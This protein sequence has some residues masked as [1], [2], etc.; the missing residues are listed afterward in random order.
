MQKPGPSQDPP[1][2]AGGFAFIGAGQEAQSKAPIQETN[3]PL[4][5]NEMRGRRIG[6]SLDWAM[7]IGLANASQRPRQPARVVHVRGCLPPYPGL[8]DGLTD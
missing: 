5:S 2:V 8:T 1:G 3:G 7:I 4:K 6:D